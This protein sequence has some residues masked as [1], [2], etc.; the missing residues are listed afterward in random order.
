MNIKKAG[1]Q[2]KNTARAYLAKDTAGRALIPQHKQ[3]PIILMGAPGIGKTEIISQIAAELGI[4][5]LT[6]SMT[7]HTRQ[8]AMGL[9]MIR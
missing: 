1:E 2:I 9:P 6:Y 4:G 7:H 3:R 8:S 5:L